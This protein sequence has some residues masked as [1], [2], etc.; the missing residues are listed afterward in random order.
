MPGGGSSAVLAAPEVGFAPARTDRGF[1]AA[2]ALA[3]FLGFSIGD[4]LRPADRQISAKAGIAAIDAYRA[5]VGRALAGTGIVSCRFEPSCSAY[6]REAIRRYGSPRGFLLTA[7]RIARCHPFAR[8][9]SD[10]VP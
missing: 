1:R 3:A 2:L 9:G 10:P 4:A 7:T 6:G 5:T 8:G